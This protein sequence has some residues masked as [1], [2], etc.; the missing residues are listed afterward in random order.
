M[1]REE[2]VERIEALEEDRE[3]TVK[4][5][6]HLQEQLVRIDGFLSKRRSEL[7]SEHKS[8]ERKDDAG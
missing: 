3:R 6:A 4:H 1:T 8:N 5:I 7:E 2:L